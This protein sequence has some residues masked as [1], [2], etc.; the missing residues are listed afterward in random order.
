MIQSRS[1]SIADDMNS[2]R[3]LMND[4]ADV[5]LFICAGWKLQ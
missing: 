5:A 1:N 4:K 3:E 2:G